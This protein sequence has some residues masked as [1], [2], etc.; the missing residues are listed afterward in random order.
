MKT[1]AIVSRKGGAGKTTLALHLAVAAQIKKKE[2]AVIDLDPQ[3]SATGWG[4]SRESETP[5]VVSAQAAR[6]PK[7]LET[8]LKEGADLTI[9][10]TAPHS[11]T[12]ALA[13]IRAADLILI[14]CRPAILDL[15]AI[16]D[17]IDLVNIAKKT[18]TVI[19]NAVPPRGSLADEAVEAIAEYGLDVAPVS[20]GNRAAF[21]HALTAGQ[22]AQEYEPT[23]KAASEIQQL[24][25][26]ICKQ[27]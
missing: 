6:L 3:A 11:E 15:R 5:V 22:T 10:D 7:I 2:V 21:I 24:Y 27:L 9:I 8:A 25:K 19:L 18:A 17:T 16:G 23:G 26:W 13:A 1:I 14:P 4:D 12:A 20:L